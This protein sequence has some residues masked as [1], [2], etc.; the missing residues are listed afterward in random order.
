MQIEN[1]PMADILCSSA[2]IDSWLMTISWCMKLEAAHLHKASPTQYII[3][4]ISDLHKCCLSGSEYASCAVV[5]LHWGTWGS[6]QHAHVT[7][8]SHDREHPYSCPPHLWSDRLPQER[9]G[10]RKPQL[11]ALNETD[12]DVCVTGTA[13]LSEPISH[14]VGDMLSGSCQHTLL[15]SRTT[16]KVSHLSCPSPPSSSH[17]PSLPPSSHLLSHLPSLPPTI[18]LL[19]LWKMI[20]LIRYSISWWSALVII[21]ASV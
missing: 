18:H 3:S 19:S 1:G 16:L 2:F 20:P 9:L 17:F 8:Q 13:A 14:E 10:R 11:P 7:R 6:L 21:Q 4:T 12:S 15:L 5:C